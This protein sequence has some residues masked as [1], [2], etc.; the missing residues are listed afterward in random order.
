[1]IMGMAL[2]DAMGL[3]ISANRTWPLPA[4]ADPFRGYAAGDWSADVDQAVIAMQAVIAA[5]G[6]S[7]SAS[8][9]LLTHE[10]THRLHHWAANGIAEHG[11]ER[12][13]GLSGSLALVIKSP[14][15]IDNPIETAMKI[16]NDGGRRLALNS[17]MVRAV[18]TACINWDL[19]TS[20][21]SSLAAVW[22]ELCS[23][24][25]VDPRV[26]YAFTW[27]SQ[28]LAALIGGMAPKNAF[29]AAD[30]SLQE[31][32]GM[33]KA[34]AQP[35]GE[36]A[37]ASAEYNMMNQIVESARDQMISD[38]KLAE[39]G[40]SAHVAKCLSVAAY[41]AYIIEYAAESSSR[42]SYE[43]I[44]NHIASAGGNVTVNCAV[45]GAILGAHLGEP[46]GA[47][48]LL[49]YDWLSRLVDSFIGAL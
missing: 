6:Q 20:Q 23:L 33:Y 27:F 9:Q 16:W 44:I 15:F 26:I 47:K 11:D 1:M 46:A 25:H 12:A 48:H 32:D 22:A 14:K 5:A 2:G 17:S 18:T 7:S 40:R 49:H 4:D 3:A 10:L 34:S 31:L 19:S 41:T 13:N 35:T 21:Q 24:T 43:K 28:Y 39:V 45:A 8:L 36:P 38:L 29:G 30:E 42:P 37:A